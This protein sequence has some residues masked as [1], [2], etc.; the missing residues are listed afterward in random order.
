MCL[1]SDNWVWNPLSTKGTNCSLSTIFLQTIILN[2]LVFYIILAWIYGWYNNM[3]ESYLF[4]TLLIIAFFCTHFLNL[5]FLNLFLLR[6][7]AKWRIRDAQECIKVDL[8]WQDWACKVCRFSVLFGYLT[9]WDRISS[10]YLQITSI[11]LIYSLTFFWLSP[12]LNR[13]ACVT[14]QVRGDSKLRD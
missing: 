9:R 11:S 6:R 1:C 5:S 14:R 8:F 3:F 2:L 4:I 12:G 13:L 10:R 7:S